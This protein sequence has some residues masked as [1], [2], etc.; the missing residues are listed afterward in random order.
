MALNAVLPSLDLLDAATVT[1]QDVADALRSAGV[2]NVEVKRFTGKNG[3][4]DFIR[5]VVPDTRGRRGGGDAPTLGIVGRLG[6]IGTRPEK[7]GLVSDGDGA[8]AAVACALKLGRMAGKGDRLPGDVLISTHI[9]PDAPV[10]QH[11]VVT[12]MNSPVDMTTLDAEEVL[13]EMEAVLT[14]DTTR[15]NRI[16][17]HRG[18]AISPTV[19]QGWI[20]RISEDL[21][22]I[23]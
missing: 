8:V 1:G 9:C 19:M 14:V 18:I 6:D 3:S 15:G 20:L 17:N 12:M 7:V 23:Q 13:P 5:V 16:V 22:T 11:P 21:L 10:I 4:T 2:P